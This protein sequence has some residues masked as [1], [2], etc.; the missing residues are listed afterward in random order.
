MSKLKLTGKQI[1]AIGYPEGPVVSIAMH[2][3]CANYKHH[4]EEDALQILK[5]ILAAPHEYVEDTVLGKI[6]EQLIAEP[7]VRGLRHRL[8]PQAR[9]PFRQIPYYLS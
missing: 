7:E 1:R 6:A 5:E 4:S 8:I 2:V 3:M 9:W